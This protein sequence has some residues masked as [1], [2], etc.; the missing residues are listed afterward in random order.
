MTKANSTAPAGARTPRKPMK[1][2]KPYPDFPLFAHA[3]KRWAKKILGT[4][5]YFGPWDDP[6][7]ALQNYLDQKDDLYARRTPRTKAGGLMMSELCGRYMTHKD[8]ARDAGEITERTRMEY[9]ATCQR[10]VDM[11]GRDRL[12]I[13]LATDDFERLRASIA[14][15]WG[16]TRLGNEI[17]RIRSVFKYGYDAAL[18][19]TPVRFGPAFR[20]PS[21][22]VL[23][24]QRNAKGKRMFVPAEIKKMLKASSL[25]VKGMILLGINCGFG[26]EDCAT[27]PI[28]AIDLKTGWVRFPRPKT[29][30]DRA[31][32]LWP[33]TVTAL[34]DV[35]RKRKE[36]AD[37]SLA[38]LVFITKYGGAWSAANYGSA[39]TH[40]TTK[41][42]EEIGIKRPGLSFYALRHTFRT[43]ADGSLD[44]PA[45][46]RIMGHSREEDMATHYR[47]GIDD[48]R[49]VAVAEHVRAWLF[50]KPEKK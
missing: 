30:V 25:Q 8:H 2:E 49:I 29:G 21:R 33:E 36:P 45:I 19:A 41:I 14:K 35:L 37:E 24:K 32:K 47:E 12:V 7:K 23:R 31:C 5:H 1:P 39:I 20:R 46:D 9:F 28:G 13:D 44:Q 40:E 10:L 3:T 6:D 4:Q 34:R 50:G 15:V 38:N 27:L 43:V 26:N 42:L 22:K 18:I 48:A 11:F 16:P 17:Q